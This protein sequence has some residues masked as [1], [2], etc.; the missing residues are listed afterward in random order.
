MA[1][2]KKEEIYELLDRVPQSALE[3]V[4][5]YLRSFEGTSND[6]GRLISNLRDILDEDKE[7]LNKLAQ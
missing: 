7:L 4:L 3:H 1:S 2:T 5:S 6:Q